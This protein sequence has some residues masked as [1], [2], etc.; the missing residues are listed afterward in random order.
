M[1]ALTGTEQVVVLGQA[2][3]HG[4]AADSFL[5]TTAAIA[6]LGQTLGPTGPTGTGATGPTGPTGTQGLTG[7]SGGPT[8]NTGPIGPTGPGVGSTGPTGPSGAAGAAGTTGATGPGTGSTGPTGPAGSGVSGATILLNSSGL[9]PQYD[10]KIGATGGAAQNGLGNFQ[11]TAFESDF[12]AYDGTQQFRVG[13]SANAAEWFEA[14]GGISGAGPTLYANNGTTSGDINGTFASQGNGGFTFCN[15][16][17]PMFTVIP[18]PNEQPYNFLQFLARASGNP[19]SIFFSGADTNVNGYLSAQGSGIIYVANSSGPIGANSA[20]IGQFG[21][22]SGSACTDQ[23][24]MIGQAS[25]SSYNIQLSAL[26]GGDVSIGSVLDGGTVLATSATKGFVRIP[27]MAGAPS[28]VPAIKD[29]FVPIVYDTTDNWLWVYN[30]G[31]SLW[32]AIPAYVDPAG[33]M[34]NNVN[35]GRSATTVAPIIGVV[36]SDTNI[37]LW[38]EPKGTGN[39]VVLNTQ[40]TLLSVN[41]N[42]ATSTDHPTFFAGTSTHNS[43]LKSSGTTN[44]AIGGGVLATN[45]T[46][47]FLVAPSCAGLPTGTPV[48]ASLD[49]VPRVYDTTNQVDMVYTNSAW[50]PASGR[51]TL[52]ANGTVAGNG[53]DLTADTLMTFTMAAS[54]L[55]N[56]GDVLRIRANGRFAS[57]TDVKTAVLKLGNQVLTT[58]TSVN[59]VVIWWIEVDVMKTASNAQTFGSTGGMNG[60]GNSGATNGTATQTDTNALTILLTGQNATNSVANSVTCQYFNIEYIANGA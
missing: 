28:G 4:P 36:G 35:I 34:V 32:K 58:T 10:V 25:G 57:S 29:T 43:I 2:Q 22:S 3:T 27:N 40:G 15:W 11:V 20:P 26:V 52:Y 7:P 1:T 48:L 14:R 24:R 12:F 8:G 19:P 41:S 37:S 51:R 47:N 44:I 23:F 56:V 18:A 45:A 30:N 59:G 16:F 33:T 5:T 50:Q 39:L 55:K 6:T 60:T 21:N 49:G 46:V 38:L 54:Q 9:A 13:V 17:G 42:G 53:A 31:T